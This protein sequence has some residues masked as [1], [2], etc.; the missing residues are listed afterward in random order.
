MADLSYAYL[1]FFFLTCDEDFYPVIPNYKIIQKLGREPQFDVVKGKK[2]FKDLVK[3]YNV[4]IIKNPYIDKNIE[5][6]KIDQWQS[7]VGKERIFIIDNPIASIDLVM[8]AIAGPMEEV[9]KSIASIWKKED[10]RMKEYPKRS[11]S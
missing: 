9:L 5:Q 1:P 8:G 10:K 11:L 6:D 2:I 3:K 4:F 7:A